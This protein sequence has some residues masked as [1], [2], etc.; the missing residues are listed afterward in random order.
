MTAAVGSYDA[1]AMGTATFVE[2]YNGVGYQTS[3]G[4]YI[5]YEDLKFGNDSF[6]VAMWIKADS[7][8][9]NDPVLYGNQTWRNGQDDGFNFI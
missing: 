5:S 8:N 9:G 6:A 4:N 3:V 2:G 7:G 1:T